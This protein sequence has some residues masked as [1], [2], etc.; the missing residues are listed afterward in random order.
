ME[1]L[2]YQFYTGK[3]TTSDVILNANSPDP[4]KMRAINENPNWLPNGGIMQTSIFDQYKLGANYIKTNPAASNGGEQYETVCPL[5]FGPVFNDG[6]QKKNIP[7]SAIPAYNSS[8][9]GS[10]PI[11]ASL[12]AAGNLELIRTV[13]LPAEVAINGPWGTHSSPI[14]DYQEIVY[15]MARNDYD[16]VSDGSYQNYKYWMDDGEVKDFGLVPISNNKVQFIAMS[17]QFGCADDLFAVNEYIVRSSE[18]AFRSHA[19]DIESSNSSTEGEK[20][21]VAGLGDA[22]DRGQTASTPLARVYTMDL[23]RK[24]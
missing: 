14:D 16:F 3:N 22:L 24:A 20:T 9:Q 17:C 4:D 12:V 8:S 6:F 18:R 7:S 15:N 1:A 11:G 13:H 23:L 10:I 21:C 19:L 2:R 5:F